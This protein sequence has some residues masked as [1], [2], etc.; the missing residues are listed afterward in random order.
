MVKY[1]CKFYAINEGSFSSPKDFSDHKKLIYSSDCFIEI[2]VQKKF[3]SVNFEQQ[4]F[5]CNLCHRIWIFIHPYFPFPGY[6]SIF[7]EN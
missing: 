5:E 4:W 2:K 6:W 7:N 3:G 1:N